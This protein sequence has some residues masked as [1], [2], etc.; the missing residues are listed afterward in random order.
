[1]SVKNTSIGKARL[2]GALCAGLLVVVVNGI[3]TQFVADRMTYHP[4]LGAPLFWKI[5]NPF[6]WWEW[7]GTFFGASPETFGYAGAICAIGVSVSF[8]VANIMIGIRARSSRKNDGSHGT[9]HFASPEEVKESGLRPSKTASG[10]VVYCGAYFDEKSKRTQ[11]LRHLGPEHICAIAPTRSGKGVGLVIPTMLSWTES[12][13]ALD[14]K[15][16]LYELTSGWRQ[17]GGRN[18]VLRF[19]PA[20]ELGSCA[21]NPL[22]EI[23]FGTRHQIGDAQ[24]IALMVIDTDGKGLFDH[25]RT[26]A[27][28]LLVGIIIHNLYKAAEV[29]RKPSLQDCAH[30][31]TGVGDFSPDDEKMSDEMKRALEDL[32]GE[33]MSVSLGGNQAEQEAQLTIRGTGKRFSQTAEKEML[34]IISTA[35]NSL[36]LYRDPIVGGNTSHSDFKIADLMD[37][38][39]PVSLYFVTV[40]ENKDRMKPLAR[41]LLTQILLRLTGP[42]KYVNGRAITNHKHKLL[43]MLDEFPSLGKLEILESALAYIAGWGI[44]AYLITQ[45]VQQLYKAYTSY[46]SIISNC[47]VRI[48]FAPNKLETAEWLSKMTG[49]TTVIKEQISTSGKRFGGGAENYSRSYQESRRPLMTPDEIQRLPAPKKDEDGNIL[50]AGEMLIFVAGQPVIRGRQILYFLDPT[51]SERSRIPPP[52]KSDTV[53]G[54]DPVNLFAV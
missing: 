18:V 13:F 42:M 52:E 1:M 6:E 47:H 14:P 23:R 11:Y 22:E 24:N 3:C 36:S 45:D 9:A 30:V 35:N 20:E 40:F 15:G 44:K 26:A 39:R 10:A 4:S 54:S 32:F 34:S 16:E 31:L 12:V 27:H 29:G 17:N 28:E 7:S 25:W 51:F 46:E 38:E 19:D 8:F 21:W 41:L 37:Y 33:M 2:Q 53:R 50:E 49:E 5:Y 48:A 43:L